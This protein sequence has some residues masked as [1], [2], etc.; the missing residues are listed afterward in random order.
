MR[1]TETNEAAY[2]LNKDKIKN[3]IIN[4][5]NARPEELLKLKNG[6]LDSIININLSFLDV[7]EFPVKES[8]ALANQVIVV[9]KNCIYEVLPKGING[10]KIKDYLGV[11][12]SRIRFWAPLPIRGADNNPIPIK[13]ILRITKAKD[14]Y[15][16]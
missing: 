13:K 3:R 5:R 16:L 6:I 14:I 1:R 10:D 12:F 7:N 4:K 8:F 2:N 15:T 11:K 9:Y